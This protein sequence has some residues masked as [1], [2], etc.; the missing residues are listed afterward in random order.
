VDT[1]IGKHTVN[2]V[3]TET[4]E[5]FADH[6]T[7]ALTVEDGVEEARAQIARLAELGIDFDQITE[8]LQTEGV[9]KFA[10]SFRDLLESVAQKVPA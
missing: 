1:L 6:G 5:A 10:A 2:T 8:D 9:D 3:P 7:V 4:L